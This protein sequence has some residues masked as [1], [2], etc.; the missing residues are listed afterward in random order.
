MQANI[1][2]KSGNLVSKDVA[3]QNLK[4]TQPSILQLN[5]APEKVVKFE[6]SGNDLTLIL[7]DGNTIVVQDFFVQTADGQRSDLVLLDDADVLWW[8]QYHSPW[9]QFHFTEIEWQDDP[10]ALLPAGGIP[11]WLI[12]G[13]TLLGIGAAAGGGGGGGGGGR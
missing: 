8:G 13:L 12:A 2:A 10:A 6:R 3:I 4:L 11:G 5:I 1:V 7:E 9:Q